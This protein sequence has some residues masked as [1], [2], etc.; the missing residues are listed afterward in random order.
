M[1][2]QEQE[3]R[4]AAAVALIAA[5]PGYE[6]VAQDLVRLLQ[7]QRIRFVPALI[8]RAH[9]GL[10]GTIHLGPEPLAGSVLSLAETLVHEH[11]HL[12]RQSHFAKTVSFWT[13]I[14]TRTPV[15]ARYERPAYDAALRFLQAAAHAH[16]DLAEEAAAEAHAVRATFEACYKRNLTGECGT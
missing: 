3:T 13:G 1:L 2:S 9:A 4:I 14:F 16:P 6:A 12:R 10:T 15:M 8:D 7:R 5:T 11:F